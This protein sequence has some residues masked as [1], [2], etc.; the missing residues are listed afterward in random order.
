MNNYK[1]HYL[2]AGVLTKGYASYGPNNG[3]F[4]EYGSDE[5]SCWEGHRQIV[6]KPSKMIF[7][8]WLQPI[9]D[10]VDEILVGLPVKLSSWQ[11]LLASGNQGSTGCLQND[12]WTDP[13]SCCPFASIAQVGSGFVVFIA[14]NVSSDVW[15][16]RCPQNTIWLSNICQFLESEAQQEIKRSLSH[17]RSPYSV[18]LSHRSVDKKLV[19][20]VAE[21]LKSN[22]VGIWFDEDKLVPSDSLVMEIDK[23]LAGMTHFTLFWSEACVGAPWVER[24]LS[25][26]VKQLIDAKIP[27]LVVRLDL[28]SVPAIIGDLYRIEA[29]DM[30]SDEIGDYISSALEKLRKRGDS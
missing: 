28:T 23:G 13:N 12:E 6:C 9:Y 5:S 7:N 16:S 18:F 25:S 14:G 2:K 24:E 4:V 10:R 1:S 22:G 11:G 27:L 29:Q 8:D 15:C 3:R 20:G 26:A 30:A 19:R 21:K 17:F